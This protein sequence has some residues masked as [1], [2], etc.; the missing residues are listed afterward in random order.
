[1]NKHISFIFMFIVIALITQPGVSQQSSNMEKLIENNLRQ[2]QYEQAYNRVKKLLSSRG[3]DKVLGYY[4]YVLTALQ[5]N[6]EPLP[7]GI[8]LKTVK[9]Y[10]ELLK[11]ADS[12]SLKNNEKAIKLYEQM[13]RPVRMVIQIPLSKF[14]QPVGYFYFRFTTADADLLTPLQKKQYQ[15]LN[16]NKMNFKKIAFEPYEKIV[17]D[18]NFYFYYEIQDVPVLQSNND[19]VGYAIDF[20]QKGI[21]NGK[22]RKHHIELKEFILPCNLETL[23]DD[24]AV[25]LN[26]DKTLIE[27]RLPEGYVRLDFATL[28]P[29]LDLGN[30]DVLNKDSYQKDG[31]LII[32]TADRDRLELRIKNTKGNK[33]TD[34][35]ALP[36]AIGSLAL[37]LFIVSR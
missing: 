5:W 30:L 35:I 6:K 29:T 2:K 36:A 19:E 17:D 1:M 9:K 20:W 13:F 4:Y 26:V 18:G 14:Q 10:Y 7:Q 34:S 8:D 32:K 24:L 22:E 21:I 12:R 15:I 31:C 33:K 11:K 28:V 37:I 23:N 3:K 25:L 27:S 16:S